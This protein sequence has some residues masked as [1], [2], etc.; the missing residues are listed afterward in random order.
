MVM[1]WSFVSLP[2]FVPVP[3][4][5]QHR[6]TCG[7]GPELPTL[8][9]PADLGD[10]RLTHTGK[11]SPPFGFAIVCPLPAMTVS[12]ANALTFNLVTTYQYLTTQA[13]SQASIFRDVPV[14]QVSRLRCQTGS[15]KCMA[16]NSFWTWF[17]LG[18]ISGNKVVLVK[19]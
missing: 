1:V 15:V 4:H 10:F 13:S 12:Q 19:T 9:L 8:E 6:L 18:F 17:I 5:H 11:H 3:G 16:E 2:G 14:V 7:T